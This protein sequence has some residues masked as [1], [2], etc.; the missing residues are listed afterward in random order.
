[1]SDLP[2]SEQ[3]PDRPE[4]PT[5][6]ELRSVSQPPAVRGRRNSEHWVADVY[7]RGISPYLTRILLEAGA[8][9]HAICEKGRTPLDWAKER[10]EWKVGELIVVYLRR[11]QEPQ[12]LESDEF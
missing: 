3:R 7:L 9:V 6:A 8:D 2:D 12:G 10:R 1:M 5:I 11:D 4:H